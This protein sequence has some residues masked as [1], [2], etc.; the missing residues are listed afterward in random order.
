MAASA[1]QAITVPSAAATAVPTRTGETEAGSV[2]GR[3]PANQM[4]TGLR[5][6]S[7]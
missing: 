4:F 6:S 5:V 7:L 2:R 3:A 1:R